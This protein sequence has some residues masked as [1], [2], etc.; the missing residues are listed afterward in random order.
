MDTNIFQR[1]HWRSY[2]ENERVRAPQFVRVTGIFKSEKR[3]G[4]R[5]GLQACRETDAATVSASEFAQT[6]KCLV[7]FVVL[8]ELNGSDLFGVS[9]ARL[10]SW[11]LL[12]SQIGFLRP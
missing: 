8:R 12:V 1:D 5:E 10:H 11:T 3:K 7:E 4:R 2:K 9:S 6:C